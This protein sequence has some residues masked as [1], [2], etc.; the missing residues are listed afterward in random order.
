MQ[1]AGKLKKFIE[2]GKILTNGTEILSLVEDYT[3]PFQKI[4]Q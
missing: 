3:T 1:L 2:N 4:P